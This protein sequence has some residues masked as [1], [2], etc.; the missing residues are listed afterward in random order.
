[1]VGLFANLMRVTLNMSALAAL[2][3]FCTPLL[4][5]RYS[6]SW[7]Y[8]VWMVI[9]VRLLIPFQMPAIELPDLSGPFQS[10]ISAAWT[11]PQDSKTQISQEAEG[12][13]RQDAPTLQE[14]SNQIEQQKTS[15]SSSLAEKKAQTVQTEHLWSDWKTK[16]QTFPWKEAGVVHLG[17]GR[18]GGTG[19]SPGIL[20]QSSVCFAC[21][22]AAASES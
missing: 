9:T 22:C 2:I 6:A 3:L 13:T 4:K 11:A 5:K 12:Q 10:A 20:L 17:V 18:R 8:W 1:M 21:L 19:D 15:E 16:L 7:R 14:Q